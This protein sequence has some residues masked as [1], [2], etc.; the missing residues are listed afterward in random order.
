[1]VLHWLSTFVALCYNYYEHISQFE[2]IFFFKTES[3]K[4]LRNF[5]FQRT[6]TLYQNN[7]K[8]IAS[9]F[10]FFEDEINSKEKVVMGGAQ[11]NNFRKL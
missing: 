9:F 5:N 1:M 4:E 8:H 6:K 7:F 2:I 3:I 11:E 10:T